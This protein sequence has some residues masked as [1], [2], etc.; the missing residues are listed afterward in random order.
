MNMSKKITRIE[1]GKR[2]K[3]RVNV[4]LDE[5]YAFSCSA[6]L[7]YKHNLKKDTTI[8][9]ENIY[10]II[11]KD[12]TMKCRSSALRIVERSCK[13]E[14]EIREKLLL[15]EYDENSINVTVEFLKEY[16]LIDDEKYAKTYVKDR[17]K[18]EGK[19]KIKYSLKRKGINEEQIL[20]A[21]SNIDSDE[22]EEI[23]RKLAIKKYNVL[24]KRESDKLKLKQ[25]MTRFLVSKGYNYELANRVINS[26]INED[27]EYGGYNE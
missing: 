12:N 13:T 25:K 17:M 24:T 1:V 20:E 5:E 26:I 15:K 18:R 14:D 11:K 4:Y 23:A 19:N 7:M 10:D 22:E 16:S 9:E 6:E 8:D 2:N 27:I 3:D 21:I